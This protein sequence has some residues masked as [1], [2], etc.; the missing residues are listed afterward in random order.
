MP[1]RVVDMKKTLPC[2]R[3]LRSRS[4]SARREGFTFIEMIL[5]V[6]IVGIVGVTAQAF[7]S[8]IEEY[9]LDGAARKIASDI[10]YAQERAVEGHDDYSIAFDTS[11]NLY[12]LYTMSPSAAL[13]KDP[14]TRENFIV[15]LDDDGY[16]GVTMKTASFGGKVSLTFD[17]MGVPSS[18]GSLTIQSGNLSRAITVLAETGLVKIGEV[19]K[20]VKE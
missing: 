6:T 1:K 19:V 16:A 2:K 8:G 15:D 12:A 13:L 18:G 11:R 5:I 7:F 4:L 3:S 20:A 10:R 17:K 14:L 9:R